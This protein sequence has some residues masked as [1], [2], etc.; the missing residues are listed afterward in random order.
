MPQKM[1]LLALLWVSARLQT[2]HK[3]RRK[4]PGDR[5]D[6]PGWVMITLMTAIVVL[7]LLAVFR[8]QVVEAVKKAFDSVNQGKT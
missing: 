6:V 1:F 3:E 8:D 2:L 5:G 4:Q 7:A